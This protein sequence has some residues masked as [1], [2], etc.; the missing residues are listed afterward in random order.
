MGAEP[1]VKDQ[2]SK[3]LAKRGLVYNV[4]SKLQCECTFN[5]FVKIGGWIWFY[6]KHISCNALIFKLFLEGSL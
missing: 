4:E 2:H 6:F 1:V 3:L 5:C